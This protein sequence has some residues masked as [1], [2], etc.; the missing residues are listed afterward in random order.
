M[1]TGSAFAR[2]YDAVMTGADLV[3]LARRRRSLARGARGRVL[4]IGAGTG[5]EFPY[6]PAT[7]WVAA[8]EPDSAMIDRARARVAEASAFIAL[9]VA[10]AR[11]LPFR[12]GVFDTAISALAFCTIPEPHHAAAEMRRVLRPSGTARLLEHVQAVHRPLA[13]LQ[14]ALTPVWRRVAG[15]CHLDRRTAD[16]IRRSGFNVVMERAACD[17]AVVELLARPSNTVGHG[18]AWS[19]R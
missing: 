7:A 18:E 2:F 17:G 9:V 5:L 14:T 8:I 1:T 16:V 12:D 19:L 13:L 3:G 10:D 11:A 4:E 6:Y 15:G